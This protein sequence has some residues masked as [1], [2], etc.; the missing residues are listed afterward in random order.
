MTGLQNLIEKA[1]SGNRQAFGKLIAPHT[2]RAESLIRHLAGARLK[3]KIELED[4][5]QETFLRAL[6]SFPQFRGDT[7][8]ALWGWLRAVAEHTGE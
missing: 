8:A 3:E 4:L 1:R 6:R 2:T 7:E 5:V